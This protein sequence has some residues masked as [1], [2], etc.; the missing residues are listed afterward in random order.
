MAEEMKD[1]QTATADAELPRRLRNVLELERRKGYA[2]SAVIGGLAGFLKSW[3]LQWPESERDRARHLIAPLDDYNGTEKAA[4]EAAVGQVLARLA[5]GTTDERPTSVGEQFAGGDNHK[6][7]AEEGPGTRAGTGG[8]PLRTAEAVSVPEGRQSPN[9]VGGGS[10]RS[11]GA[12]SGDAVSGL[13]T[14]G[15]VGRGGP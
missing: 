7:A 1:V 6:P 8:P 14:G 12:G 13:A 15:D 9:V 10:S 4:R 3:L 2:D 11:P 5:G